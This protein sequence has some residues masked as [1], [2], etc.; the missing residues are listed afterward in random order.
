LGLFVDE[1]LMMM[2][3]INSRPSHCCLI[4]GLYKL[5]AELQ[6]SSQTIYNLSFSFINYLTYLIYRTMG[7]YKISKN[8]F[9]SSKNIPKNK[10][11]YWNHRRWFGLSDFKL[12]DNDFLLVASLLFGPL[13]FWVFICFRS[14]WPRTCFL[15]RADGDRDNTNYRYKTCSHNFSRDFIL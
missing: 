13:V 15:K 12:W 5:D 6:G 14:R 7:T 3:I 9:G 11:V 2:C 8:W 1:F 4:N 10:E